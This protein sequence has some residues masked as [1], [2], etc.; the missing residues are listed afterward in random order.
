MMMMISLITIG[1]I[2]LLLGIAVFVAGYC[3]GFW[4]G[5][6]SEDSRKTEPKE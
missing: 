4:D 3:F 5:H 1:I 2:G 6:H